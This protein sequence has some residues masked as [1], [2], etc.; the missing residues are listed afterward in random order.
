MS[1]RRRKLKPAVAV[2]LLFIAVPTAVFSSSS[3]LSPYYRKFLAGLMPVETI[4]PEELRTAY[5][6]RNLKILLVPGHDNV[7]SGTEFNGVREADLNRGLAQELYA[8]LKKDGHFQIFATRDFTTGEYAPIFA[9]Y[10]A[11]QEKEILSFRARLTEAMITAL[12]TGQF[13]TRGGVG[14]NTARSRVIQKLY[15]I[16]KWANDNGIDVALHIHFNDHAGRRPGRAGD[17]EGFNIYVPEKQFSSSRASR[18][19]AESIFERL[20]RMFAVSN[21]AGESR[22][23]TEDQELVA[24]GANGSLDGVGLLIEYGYIYEPQFTDAEVREA[25]LTELAHQTYAGVKKYF[26]PQTNLN[27]TTLLPYSWRSPMKRGLQGSRDVLAL[28]AALRAEG[29]YPPPGKD[30]ADC[31][32]SGNF[33]SCTEISVALFQ[34]K[35]ADEILNPS[36]LPS[37]TGSAGP[38]TIRKLNSLYGSSPS[39][40]D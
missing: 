35:Y 9:S 18:A 3:F 12:K 6:Q 32:L 11:T 22:G 34:E 20:K 24:V 17:Y 38:A 30:L 4:T 36:G 14:H 16:N 39:L 8:I 33:G 40:R 10:F 26:E 21:L 23:I 5:R 28:Q 31:S 15:G 13:R 29:F 27:D 25:M 2:F 37:G 1:D 19:L 7:D